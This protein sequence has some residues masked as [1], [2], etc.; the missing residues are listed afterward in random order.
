MFN[1]TGSI[2]HNVKNCILSLIPELS[3]CW[4][5]VRFL[6][7]DLVVCFFWRKETLLEIYLIVEYSFV[8]FSWSLV[9]EYAV[10]YREG[11]IPLNFIWTSHWYRNIF[12]KSICNC[13]TMNTTAWHLLPLTQFHIYSTA[14]WLPDCSMLEWFMVYTFISLGTEWRQCIWLASYCFIKAFSRPLCLL[15]CNTLSCCWCD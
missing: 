13:Y 6:R 9:T 11:M 5:C 3:S 8:A 15:L 12:I 7:Y 2:I 4:I 14:P 1:E 10:I